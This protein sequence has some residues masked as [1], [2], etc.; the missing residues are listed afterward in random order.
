MSSKYDPL[1]AYLQDQRSKV[2]TLTFTQIE[3]I[4]GSPLPRSARI[5]REWWANEDPRDTRHV[6]CRAWKLTGRTA[7]PNLST[8]TVH[9]AK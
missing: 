2:V 6:Q 9:F 8:S 1:K 5:R 4:L 7:T 3:K